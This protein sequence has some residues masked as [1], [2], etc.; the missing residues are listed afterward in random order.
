MIVVPYKAEHLLALKMQPA[1]GHCA[2]YITPEYAR[3]LER[4]YA[5]TALEGDEVL[6]VGGVTKLWEN[7]AIVWSFI[8]WRAAKHMVPIHRAVK[9]I[10]DLAPYKRLEA[11]TPCEFKQGHRWLRMLGFRME[12]ERMEAYRVD[13]GDSALYAR[14]K[15]G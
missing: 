9:K 8:D 13:G 14:V 6:A 1:Q 4:E 3:M 12:A 11:D 5:F 2:Q 7:R 10:L 15:H